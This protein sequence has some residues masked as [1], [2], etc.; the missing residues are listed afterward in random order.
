[1]APSLAPAPTRVCNSSIKRITSPSAFSTSFRTA[2]RRSSNSPLYLAPA[3]SAPISRATTLL[4]SRVSETSPATTRWARPSTIAVFPTPGSPI[5]T[6]LFFLRRESTWT[7]RRI[8]SSR[9]ITGSSL[10]SRARSVRLRLNLSRAWYFSSG[11]GSVIRWVPRISKRT[12]KINSLEIPFSPKILAAS[13]FF[14]SDM[15]RKMCSILTYWSFI[16]A[17]SAK[18]ASRT[19]FVRGEIKASPIVPPLTF[20]N[21][22][23]DASS[24]RETSSEETPNLSSMALAIPSGSLSMAKSRCSGSICWFLCSEAM[25]WAF[26]ISFCDFM[27]NLS[28][29]INSSCSCY[30]QMLRK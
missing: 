28:K 8:S 29:R 20:G 2:F 1:M 26:W 25:D 16:L 17:A 12:F 15:A 11:L 21:L 13:P 7:I 10:P 9:P 30:R 22:S 24:S 5:K 19:V 18:A 3:I 14:S 23:M 27:V 4:F 6:G